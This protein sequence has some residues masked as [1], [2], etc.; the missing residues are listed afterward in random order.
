MVSVCTNLSCALLGAKRVYERAA[1]ILQPDEEGLS[2]DGE[3][4]L[5]EEECLGAC[6]AA[7]VVQVNFMNHDRV[8]EDRMAELIEAIRKGEMP[9]PSRGDPPGDFKQTSR[10]LAGLSPDRGP[11]LV[12]GTDEA[13]RG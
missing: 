3:F 2:A 9:Q 7:P 4:T 1:E 12:P 11:G 5:H 10:R 13:N 8:D 6:D